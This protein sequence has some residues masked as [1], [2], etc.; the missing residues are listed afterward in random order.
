MVSLSSLLTSLITSAIIGSI[1]V[2]V[3]AILAQIRG[4]HVIYYSAKAVAGDPPPEKHKRGVLQWLKGIIHVNEEELISFAGLDA[5]VYLRFL[6]TGLLILAW[7]S[8]YCLVVL[9]P[10]CAT[11]S[12][13]KDHNQGLTDPKKQ[14]KY[15]DFDKL[16]MGNIKPKSNRLWACAIGAYWVTL[17]A[18]YFLLKTYTEITEM[19]RHQA[20]SFGVERLA[21]LVR[22]VPAAADSQEEELGSEG[23]AA[24]AVIDSYMGEIHGKTYQKSLLVP[25]LK[26]AVKAWKAL[27]K[28][29]RKLAHARAALQLSEAAGK[30][31]RPMHKT[32]MLGLCGPKVDSVDYWTEQVELLVPQLQAHQRDAISST[33]GGAALS[34]FTNA[35]SAASASQSMHEDRADRWIVS[36]APEPREVVWENLAIPVYQR[37]SRELTVYAIMFLTVCFYMI[38]IALVS[39]FTTMENLRKSLPFLKAI[40][41][42]PALK[43]FLEAFLPQLALIVFLALLPMFCKMLSKAEGIPSES[44]IVRATSGKL[45][46]F[47]IFNVFLGVTL[48]GSLFN[49]LQQIIKNPGSVVDLLGS[50]L[51]QNS[52]FFITFIA[53]KFLVG[54]GLELARISPLIIYTIKRKFLC[55]TEQELNEAWAPKGLDYAGLVPDDMLVVTLGLCYAVIAPMILPFTV[56]YFAVSYVV[57]KNQALY[58]YVPQ[59]ESKGRMWPHIHARIVVALLIAQVTALGYFGIKKFAGTVFMIPLPFI[60]IAYYLYTYSKFYRSY[61]VTALHNA[62][63]DKALVPSGDQL[64]AAY[65]PQCLQPDDGRPDELATPIDTKSVTKSDKSRKTAPSDVEPAYEV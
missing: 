12:F 50:S 41:D 34:F 19:R 54:K 35:V 38:P 13:Y 29:K 56:C 60:T 9:L 37:R 15:D 39:S 63:R 42:K 24:A 61:E 10:I 31:K 49:A 36:A 28:A 23:A 53:L 6:Y 1:L 46:Y 16:A 5:A 51:P 33:A 11:D 27:D 40:I 26:E 7:A 8:L 32:K 57:F 25:A 55:K 21:V 17:G 30:P 18:L 62:A 52:T 64:V 44:H 22:D 20:V 14:L 65:M 2:L 43:S 58:V 45:F 3:F 4:N 59:Y 47:Q 48:A